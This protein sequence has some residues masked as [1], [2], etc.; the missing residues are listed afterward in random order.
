MAALLEPARKKGYLCQQRLDVDHKLQ[1]REGWF[2]NSPGTMIPDHS[3][4]RTPESLVS[5]ALKSAP[6]DYLGKDDRGDTVCS[7]YY[8]IA[9]ESIFYP[10]SPHDLSY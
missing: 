2:N 1:G 3:S 4:N 8:M 10:S 7:S 9:H 5:A 6:F